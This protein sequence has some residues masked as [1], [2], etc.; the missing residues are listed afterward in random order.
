MMTPMFSPAAVA[1]LVSGRMPRPEEIEE[2]AAKIWRE[3]YA[4]VWQIEWSEVERGSRVYRS[5][6]AA[7]LMALGA[8]VQFA[9]DMLAAAV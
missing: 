4:R 9:P 2:M 8:M 6:Y 5:I 3:A 1:C 7:A